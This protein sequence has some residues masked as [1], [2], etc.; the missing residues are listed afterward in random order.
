MHVRTPIYNNIQQTAL[1][2][3]QPPVNWVPGLFL[4]GLAV[5]SWHCPHSAPTPT[6]SGCISLLPFGP[7]WPIRGEVTPFIPL[8]PQKNQTQRSVRLKH[9]AYVSMYKY[10]VRAS[11]G[12]LLRLL[13]YS[14]LSSSSRANNVIPLSVMSLY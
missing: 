3:T 7:S 2:H 8:I 5:A 12:S 6:Q 1:G 11:V 13:N 10:I 9:Y 4:G 14:L